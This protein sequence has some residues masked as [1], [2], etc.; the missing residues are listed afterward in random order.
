MSAVIH[1]DTHRLAQDRGHWCGP[2]PST[3]FEMEC[4]CLFIVAAVLP[5]LGHSALQ[6]LR[7]LLA[8]SPVLP[9]VGITEALC[10]VT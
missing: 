4:L 2:L 8:L 9:G 6:L 1:M 5:T 3:V 7:V 10:S